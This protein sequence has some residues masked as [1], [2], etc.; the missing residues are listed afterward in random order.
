MSINVVYGVGTATPWLF[1][2]EVYFR[3][4]KSWNQW[5]ET[6]ESHG[7]I[8]PVQRTETL[9]T[10]LSHTADF[11]GPTSQAI[12]EL[13]QFLDAKYQ[14]SLYWMVWVNSSDV[15]GTYCPANSEMTGSYEAKVICFSY[16]VILLFIFYIYFLCKLWLLFLCAARDGMQ[17][18]FVTV[19]FWCIWWLVGNYRRLGRTTLSSIWCWGLDPEFRACWASVRLTKLHSSPIFFLLASLALRRQREHSSLAD[20]RGIFSHCSSWPG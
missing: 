7:D 8:L 2:H 18:N 17:G 19:I 14:G 4:R 13:S 15:P 12:S 9:L 6:S 10:D 1:H 3:I 11:W 5:S 16:R 20:V